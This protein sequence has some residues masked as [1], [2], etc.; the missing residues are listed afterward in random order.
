[1]NYMNAVSIH[2]TCFDTR[3]KGVALCFKRATW[4]RRNLARSAPAMSIEC[5]STALKQKKFSCGTNGVTRGGVLLT[6]LFP[7]VS[8]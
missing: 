6:E 1:M 4:I 3:A 8:L 5:S 7:V 2:C